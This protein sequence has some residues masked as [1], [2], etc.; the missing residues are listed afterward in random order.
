[1]EINEDRFCKHLNN[2][3][4]EFWSGLADEPIEDDELLTWAGIKAACAITRYIGVR[5]SSDELAVHVDIECLVDVNV[6]GNVNH[7]VDKALINALVEHSA[8]KL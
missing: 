6:F 5:R 2:V 7:K 1:M 8:H 3:C 4:A